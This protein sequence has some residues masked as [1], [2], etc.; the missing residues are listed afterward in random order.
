MG[1]D[2]CWAYVGR[3]TFAH[4]CQGCLAGWEKGQGVLCSARVLCRHAFCNV[5]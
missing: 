5:F 1:F 2:P 4:L 3:K